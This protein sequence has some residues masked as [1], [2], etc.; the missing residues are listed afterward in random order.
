MHVFHSSMAFGKNSTT[1][2]TLLATIFSISPHFQ[3]LLLVL[4]KKKMLLSILTTNLWDH[5]C[6]ALH[7]Y[8]QI[9]FYFYSKTYRDMRVYSIWALFKIIIGLIMI[10]WLYT[11]INVYQQPIVGLSFGFLAIFMLVRGIGYFCFITWYKLFSPYLT[12]YHVSKSY[13]LGLLLGIFTLAN[14][15]LMVTWHRSRLIWLILIAVF[16][17][18]HFVLFDDKSHTSRS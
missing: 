15:S 13:K 6:Q 8:T 16:I 4:Q 10:R 3:K 2:F 7:K 9:H 17:W 11:F 18:L 1:S 12:E 14:L 5:K